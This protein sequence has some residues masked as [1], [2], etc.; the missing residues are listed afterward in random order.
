M[1]KYDSEDFLSRIDSIEDSQARNLCYFLLFQLSYSEEKIQHLRTIIKDFVTAERK[2]AEDYQGYIAND[3]PLR[4]T[5][6]WKKAWS[7]L[8]FE[9]E[10]V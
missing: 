6:E 4:M 5:S 7:A 10:K 1:S 2:Y 3:T 8:M 9:A